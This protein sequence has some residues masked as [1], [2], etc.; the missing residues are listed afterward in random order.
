MATLLASALPGH[1]TAAG[2][3]EPLIQWVA[4]P[5][6]ACDRGP[7]LVA[8][9]RA[10]AGDE[11]AAVD[12]TVSVSSRESGLHAVIE[13][14]AASGTSVRELDSPDC[15]VVVTAASLILAV[16]AEP[17]VVAAT[18]LSAEPDVGT[19]PAADVPEAPD[20]P[21]PR[22]RPRPASEPRPRSET[23]PPVPPRR[24]RLGPP[25]GAL[26]VRGLVGAAL[27]PGIGGGIGGGLTLG[28]ER[29][30]GRL[31]AAYW[32][33]GRAAL[34]RDGED[35]QPLDARV[36]VDAWMVQPQLCGATSQQTWSLLGCAGVEAGVLRGRGEGTSL[37]EARDP[38]RPWLAATL[39]GGGRVAVH[40]V[41]RLGLWVTSAISVLRTRFVLRDGTVLY[42]PPPVSV[43]G[44]LEFLVRF[45]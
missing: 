12:A 4:E 11:A 43:R 21:A 5:G 34:E 18:T 23:P 24:P 32:F 31:G 28:A 39:G 44:G 25:I 16:W 45:W 6:A 37:A 14:R 38:R 27:V 30:H 7:E 10:L 41:V 35:A 15:D 1:A 13:L 29:L 22:L 8:R 20:P 26:D 17:V 40:R 2:P 42:A 9:V 33:P 3:D 36:R 19:E